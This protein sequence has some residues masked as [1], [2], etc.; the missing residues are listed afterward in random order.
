MSVVRRVV[1]A[2]SS[3]ALASGLF[4]SLLLLTYLGTL[5]QVEH[6]LLHAQQKYFHSFIAVHDVKGIPL[7]LP[8]AYLLLLLL[9]VN[10]LLGMALRM[11]RTWA[12]AGMWMVHGGIL[13]LLVGSFVS[14]HY[15][16]SGYISLFEGESIDHYK[17]YESWE[18][19]VRGPEGQQ[20]A[21]T[22]LIPGTSFMTLRPGETALL[23]LDGLPFALELSGYMPN[24]WRMR[25]DAGTSPTAPVAEGHFLERLEVEQEHER[26]AAGLYA[27]V[28]PHD[29]SPARLMALWSMQDV[30][31]RVSAEGGDWELMLRRKQTPLPFTLRLDAFRREA[32]PG[33]DTPRA[34]SSEVT[35]IEDGQSARALIEMNAPMR[36]RGFIFYQS[37]WGPQNAGPGVDLFSV[38]AVSRNPGDRFPLYACTFIAL[39][40]GVHFAQKLTR[41][42]RREAARRE[43]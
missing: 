31:S 27:R 15:A 41:Y 37:S 21:R 36:H 20:P 13:L 17:S 3:Y 9:F 34:F 35:R 26:N 18:V 4:L 6:G 32:H 16:D 14:F 24:A 5:D 29:G 25:A 42:L 11:R 19:V 40:M 7:P 12:Q 43:P 22:V 30:P 23:P 1:M 33:T 28:I 2:L 38:L 8:G 10:V 39:G